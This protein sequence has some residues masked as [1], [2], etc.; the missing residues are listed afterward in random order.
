MLEKAEKRSKELGLSAPSPRLPLGETNYDRSEQRNFGELKNTDAE[1]N[2]SSPRSTKIVKQYSIKDD[3]SKENTDT[4]VEINITAPSN[5]QVTISF[6]FFHSN[7]IIN[8]TPN[9]G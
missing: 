2:L 4:S 8:S 9:I 3:R 5:I 6:K 7:T 1:N